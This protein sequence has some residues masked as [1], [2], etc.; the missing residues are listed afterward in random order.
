MATRTQTPHLQD[1]RIWKGYSQRELARLAH[2]ARATITHLE[3]TNG[4][5]NYVTVAKL[6]QALNLSRE[7]LLHET[8]QLRIAAPRQD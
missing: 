8:P 2:V 7:Q 4:R 5:A 6:A 1:W 3:T